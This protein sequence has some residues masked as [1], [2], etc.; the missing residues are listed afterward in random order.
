[1]LARLGGAMERG[2][3]KQMVGH[4]VRQVMEARGYQLQQGNMKITRISN[5]FSRGSRFVKPEAA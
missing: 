3:I 4:M 2:R 5:I 1:L